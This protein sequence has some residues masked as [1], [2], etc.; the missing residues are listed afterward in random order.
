MNSK[1][2]RNRIPFGR[3]PDFS[4]RRALE[5]HKTLGEA[6]KNAA[7]TFAFNAFYGIISANGGNYGDRR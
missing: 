3:F 6:G 2:R 4:P 5:I 1:N 7:K